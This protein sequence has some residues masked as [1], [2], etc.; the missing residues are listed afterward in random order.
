MIGG[1]FSH[2]LAAIGDMLMLARPK[3]A[4]RRVTLAGV[5]RDAGGGWRVHVF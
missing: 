2:G 1:L 4:F 5:F 3:A